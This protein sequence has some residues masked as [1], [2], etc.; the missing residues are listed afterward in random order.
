MK[1]IIILLFGVFLSLYFVSC[2]K[3]SLPG[4]DLP[5]L[6]SRDKEL[7]KELMVT[8]LSMAK[9]P[10]FRIQVRDEC[11]KQEHGD[12]NVYL[13]KIIEL[14]K[15]KAIF[16]NEINKIEPLVSELRELSNGSEPIIFY[17]FLAKIKTII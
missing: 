5:G 9:N 4:A 15:R 11:L 6:L 16:S 8:L 2:T 17:P 14:N 3:D 12:Y 1:T 10:D 13:A 7:K